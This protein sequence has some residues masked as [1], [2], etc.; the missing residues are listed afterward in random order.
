MSVKLY[1]DALL[2]KLLNWTRDTQVTIVS[3]DDSRT[4]F[5]VVADKNNDTP[6]QLPL[7]ALKRPGGFSILRKGK[8]P[9]SASGATLDATKYSTKQLNAIP[10]SI[11]YQI[12]IYTRYLEEA[13]EYVRNIVF[14]IINYPKLDIVIPYNDEN[15]IH[16][17]NIRLEGEVSDNSDIPERLIKGQFTRMT[18]RIYIDDAYLFDVRYRDVLKV[19]CVNTVVEGK[20]EVAVDSKDIKMK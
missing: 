2:Q 3:P 7:I 16:E 12:D 1:D 19:H 5:S 13:D 10:I 8:S 17:S 9:L 14:N 18:M 6:I 11:P 20:E 15:R 4:L